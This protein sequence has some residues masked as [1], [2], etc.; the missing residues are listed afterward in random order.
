MPV[1]AYTGTNLS[2]Q[3]A[4][5]LGETAATSDSNTKAQ[6]Y[7]W[8]TDG[9]FELSRRKNWWWQEATMSVAA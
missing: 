6:R 3:L 2:T 9:Y 8:L 4:Y 7:Q 5:R 1:M